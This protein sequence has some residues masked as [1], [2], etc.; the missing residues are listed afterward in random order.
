MQKNHQDIYSQLYGCNVLDQSKVHK[1]FMFI[2][3]KKTWGKM[4]VDNT[5][6]LKILGRLRLIERLYFFCFLTLLGFIIAVFVLN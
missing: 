3:S 4:N 1:L 6:T 2:Q 5:E